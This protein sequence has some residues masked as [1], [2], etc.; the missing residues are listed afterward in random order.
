[1]RTFCEFTLEIV[2]RHLTAIMTVNRNKAVKKL[3]NITRKF[4]SEIY[5]EKEVFIRKSK[6]NKEM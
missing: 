6:E 2:V 5:T 4:S 1:M 3:E